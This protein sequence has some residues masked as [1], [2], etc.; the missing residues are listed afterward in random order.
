MYLFFSLGFH[1]DHGGPSMNV[2]S[3]RL[4]RY[5]TKKKATFKPNP[6]LAQRFQ[7]YKNKKRKKNL[8]KKNNYT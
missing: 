2:T 6:I 8:A 7:T 5:E 3:R 1:K 4:K